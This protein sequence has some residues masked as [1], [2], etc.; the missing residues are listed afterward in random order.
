MTL[1]TFQGS[2]GR[3]Y[4]FAPKT[5]AKKGII[6]NINLQYSARGENRITTNDSL[7]FKKQ[8]FDDAKMG[9]QHSIPI[10]TN[11]KI[12]NYL[13]LS[14]SANYQE[15][16]TFKTI[17]KSYDP[18]LQETITE[19]K[20]GF[21]AFR[22]YNFSSSLGTT[23]YGMYDFGSEKK[24]QAIR[25]VVRPSI[26]YSINPAFDQYY[27]TY[28][29]ID[30]DGLTTSEVEYSRFEQSLYGSPSKNYSSSIGFSLSNNVEAKVRDRDSTK[31][32]PRKITLLNNLNFST[33]YNLAADSLQLSPIRMSGGTTLF[34]DEMNINFGA[35]FDPYAL[36]NNNNKINKYNIQ[37]G[38]GLARLTSANLTLGYQ[39]SSKD[40]D[41]E[42]KDSKDA[43]AREESQM[44]GGRDDDLFG[45]PQD[46]A[47]Q[48]LNEDTKEEDDKPT[49]HYNYKIPW[50]LRLAYAVNY[51]NSRRQN[52]ISSH[53]LMFSGDIDLSP[54]WTVGASSGYDF[55]NS[56]FTYTQLRIERDLLSWR[57][58]FSWVPF[59]DRSSWNFFI[60]ISSS[61]LKDLKYD[62][63]RQS[64]KQL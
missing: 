41:Q 42:A 11:F 50:S 64:D 17:E 62:K 33:S 21:D 55:K 39:L 56:G 52:E 8:M 26:S 27:D 3:I 58:N 38:G 14:A 5:G 45:K 32:E 36:D 34:K 53:S 54:R 46:F 29:V 20:K 47:D 24:I 43:K 12:L 18:V 25:H 7:F 49:D 44:S 57:M 48:R 22:T 13:S 61:L 30:A 40:F 31:I 19:E 2:V 60:G 1:P 9:M 37:N 16:W 35:T 63:R 6:Q 10:S 51:N 23:F 59:S 28:E 4:P 15:S